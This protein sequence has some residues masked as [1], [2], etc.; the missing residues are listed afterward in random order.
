M[1]LRPCLDCGEPST[2]PRCAEHTVDTKPSVSA[3]G[4]DQI[5]TVLSRRARRIQ[6]F[7][8]DCGATEDLQLDH[9][10]EAWARKYAG[11]PIRLRDVAVVCGPCNRSRG[12]ARGDRVT[13]GD[14]PMPS[15]PDPGGSQSFSYSDV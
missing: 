5:W 9:T 6:P 13:R 15:S 4:Y 3:R 7:C 2:G 8:T 14:A 12:A 10:P 1:T 11:K